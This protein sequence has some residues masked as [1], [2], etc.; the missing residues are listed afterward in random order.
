VSRGL[1][2]VEEAGKRLRRVADL[3]DQA[4]GSLAGNGGSSP[5]TRSA[6]GLAEAT[7]ELQSLAKWLTEPQ[8][9]RGEAVRFAVEDRL[10]LGLQLK[11]LLPKLNRA[12][13]LLAAA[14]EFYRGWCA[15]SPPQSYPSSSYQG[16]AW[17][18]SPALLA[19]EG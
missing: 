2:A 3:L 9:G 11:A 19:L 13:R 14:A 8:K 7:A 15:V 6:I 1:P 18:H 12:E 10:A 16:E 5:C 4:L 17:S